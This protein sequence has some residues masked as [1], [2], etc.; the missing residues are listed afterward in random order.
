MLVSHLK[1]STWY[2][3]QQRQFKKIRRKYHDNNQ[4]RV[5]QDLEMLR[6]ADI[7]KE[8]L[9]SHLPPQPPQSS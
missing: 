5:H 7:S 6:C 4:E 1:L 2:P 8:I 3:I 9:N